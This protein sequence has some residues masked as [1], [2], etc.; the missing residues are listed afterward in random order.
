[1]VKIKLSE[2]VYERLVAFQPIVRWLEGKNVPLDRSAEVLLSI[3]IQAL[4][5]HLW[6]QHDAATLVETLQKLGSKHPRE[7]YQFVAD[8]LTIGTK[9]QRKEHRRRLR[10]SLLPESPPFGFAA[11]RPSTGDS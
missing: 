5:N 3:G 7:V 9:I 4:L 10:E 8:V 6:Q 11:G 1:M 2:E